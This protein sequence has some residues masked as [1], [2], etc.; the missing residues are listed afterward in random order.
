MQIERKED[1][2][3]RSIAILVF[4]SNHKIGTVGERRH[5]EEEE[6]ERGGRDN[7]G[8]GHPNLLMRRSSGRRC[9]ATALGKIHR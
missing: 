9:D 6:E 2:I 5:E 8:E 1:S 3:L 7:V 4:D